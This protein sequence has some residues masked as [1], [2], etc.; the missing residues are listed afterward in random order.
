MITNGLAANYYTNTITVT[1][2]PALTRVDAVLNF[3]GKNW[4]LPGD[5]RLSR[6]A[7]QWW[8]GMRPGAIGK[9]SILAD[10]G[11]RVWVDGKMILDKWNRQAAK[12]FDLFNFK[13]KW[14]YGLRIEYFQDGGGS[15]IKLLWTPPG[16]ITTIVPTEWLTPQI[17]TPVVIPPTPTPPPPIPVPPPVTPPT[18]TPV[19]L[20][21]PAPPIPPIPVPPPPP[22]VPVPPPSPLPAIPTDTP[23]FKSSALKAKYFP[24][25]VWLAAP[26]DFDK[27]KSR[28]VN[29]VWHNEAM[30]GI[31]MDLATYTSK[32]HASGLRHWR[33]P[34]RYM[35]KPMTDA[36]DATDPTLAAYSLLDEPL[37]HGKTP[38]DY[39][40]QAAEFRACKANLP[41][42][43]NLEGDKAS[44]SISKE[45]IDTADIIFADWYPVNRRSPTSIYPLEFV[46][47]QSEDLLRFSRNADGKT[48]PVG[49]VIESSFQGL[50]PLYPGLRRCPTVDEFRCEIWLALV[51]GCRLLCYFPEDP[52]RGANDATPADIADEMVF[53]NKLIQSLA[54]VLMAEGDRLLGLNYD[55]TSPVRVARRYL[56]GQTYTV[57]LNRTAK[58]TTFG[59]LIIPPYRAVLVNPD[60]SVQLLYR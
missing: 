28:A 40:K 2:K 36:F 33:Y 12:I 9:L 16:G 38:A 43:L 11:I 56:D 5:F 53:Q 19:P 7:V 30:P 4:K 23:T 44:R 25:A 14:T 17:P 15:A 10:D 1:G 34:A 13:S 50:T 46:G 49:A 29:T 52:S 48:K 27:W 45:Y 26:E 60:N 57:V 8:G 22:P 3:D 42:I 37:L 21:P 55:I 31:P 51:Y 20:P 18:P 58:E 41:L 24:I 54:P 47:I 39:V 6:F 35:R 59:S 32:L